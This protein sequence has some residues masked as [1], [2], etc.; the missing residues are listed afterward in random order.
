[1]QWWANS[2]SKGVLRSFHRGGGARRKADS[3]GWGSWEG[4]SNPIPTSKAVWGRAVRVPGGAPTAQRC[5]TI[6][7][8]QDGLSWHYNIVNHA[9]IG[10]R[11]RDPPPV[12]VC[13]CPDQIPCA[14]F[15][16]LDNKN[17]NL[18][19][20]ISDPNPDLWPQ[21]SNLLSQ[22][23][24]QISNPEHARSSHLFYTHQLVINDRSSIKLCSQYHVQHEIF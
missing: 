7:T 5:S 24:N 21:I 19:L 9:A 1:M 3:G 15:Q 17:C 8:T 10:A 14:K 2:G 18:K 11:S 6:F 16:I 13:P 4:S 20:Q 22:I 12:C 23:S